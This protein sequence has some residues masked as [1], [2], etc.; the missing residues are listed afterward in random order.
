M[1]AARVHR[2]DDTLSAPTADVIAAHDITAGY[3]GMTVLRGVN[4]TVTPGSVVA[5]LGPNGAGKSTLL[6]V[7]SGALRPTS[8][9]VHSG[10]RDITRRP[11][12]RRAR[13]GICLI[14]EGRGVFPALTV[15]ENLRIQTPSWIDGSAALDR[16]ITAFPVL[17]QRLGQTAGTMSGG[18]QQ[19]LA[20]ARA[21][22]SQAGIVLVDEVS[23]GLAPIVVEQIFTALT[24]L[25]ASGVALLLVEQYVHIVL[26]MADHIYLLDKGEITFS[27]HPDNLDENVLLGGYLGTDAPDKNPRQHPDTETHP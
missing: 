22:T 14:P 15:R 25:A 23:M 16:A 27:G 4:L 24:T 8:G 18:E 11:P 5:L 10:A 3:R 21:W 13:L 26:G 20:L 6:R 9:T 2:D 7:L 19:M 12:H 1:T 17:G